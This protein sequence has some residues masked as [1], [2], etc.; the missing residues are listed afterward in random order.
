M[1]LQLSSLLFS[2]QKVPFR[3]VILKKLEDKA[4]HL[5]K[6]ILLKVKSLRNTE[7]IKTLKT[8]SQTSYPPFNPPRETFTSDIVWFVSSLDR[9]SP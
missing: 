2:F 6:K 5:K 8:Q 4:H 1:D 9:T 7:F 3:I